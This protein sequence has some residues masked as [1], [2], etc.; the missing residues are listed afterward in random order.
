[1]DILIVEVGHYLVYF[2]V[3]RRSIRTNN[4]LRAPE[5][6]VVMTFQC[7]IVIP[8]C[9]MERVLPRVRVVFESTESLGRSTKL[10]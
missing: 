3:V 6:K 1:M 10:A 4:K 9:F 8:P 2:V 7:V 5:R